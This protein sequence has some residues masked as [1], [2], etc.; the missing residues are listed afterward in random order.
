M[1]QTQIY[2]HYVWAT[3]SRRPTL[4]LP[5]R[6]QLFDH[7][8]QNALLKGIHLDRINGYTDHVHCLVWLQ[9]SQSVAGVAQQLK[10]ESAYWFNMLSGIKGVKLQWQESYF[11]VSVSLSQV[12]AVRNYIDNQEKHHDRKTFKEEYD[13]LMRRYLFVKNLD[14]SLEHHVLKTR[15]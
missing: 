11:A 15:R 5:Y 8:K 10:G 4:I 1:S 7:I 2:I 13:A 12:G 14:N 6:Y 9:P 3:R